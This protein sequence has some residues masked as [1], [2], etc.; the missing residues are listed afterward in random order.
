MIQSDSRFSSMF[1]QSLSVCFENGEEK[2]GPDCG[3]SFKQ[4]NTKKSMKEK[5]H[6]RKYSNNSRGGGG[7]MHL[8][9]VTFFPALL[10]FYGPP[11]FSLSPPAP[12]RHPPTLPSSASPGW[13]LLI[14]TEGGGSLQNSRSSVAKKNCT[15]NP[16]GFSSHF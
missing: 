8:L 9:V 5:K 2:R 11:P 1:P 15:K 3:N 14:Y 10:F 12:L 16:F 6:W 4:T 7:G 13:V